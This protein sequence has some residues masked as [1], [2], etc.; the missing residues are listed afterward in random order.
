MS[1]PAPTPE[2]RNP[3]FYA[4]PQPLGLERFGGWRLKRGNAAFAASAIGLPVVLGEFADASRHYPILFAAG[5]DNG[6]IVLTGL[7]DRN[8][9][10]KDGLWEEKLYIPGYLRRYPFALAGV[11]D[12]PDRLILVIDAA[13]DF[14]VNE[15]TEGIA[16][17]TGDQP[18]DFTK[19]AMKFCENWHRETLAT[20]EFRTAL[21]ERGLLVGRRVDGTLPDGRKFAVDGFEIIDQ[22]KLTDLDATTASEWHKRGW[23]ASAYF[24]LAS[25]NR[26]SDLIARSA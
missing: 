17:F 26:V 15:G 3:L 16:L 22:Q 5:D 25:L 10:V 14:F 21:R 12:D 13:S 19:D 23:L 2:S 4:D 11:L 1:V 18:S 20:H 8:V 6:P 24:H 7:L 9:F